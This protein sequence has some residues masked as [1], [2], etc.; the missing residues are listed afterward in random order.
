MERH[1]ALLMGKFNAAIR[2]KSGEARA[3]RDLDQMI[4]YAMEVRRSG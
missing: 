2:A 4:S 1:N 3:I